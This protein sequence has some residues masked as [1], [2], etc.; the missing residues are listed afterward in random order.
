MREFWSLALICAILYLFLADA[1]NAPQIHDEDNFVP[2]TFEVADEEVTLDEEDKSVT[3]QSTQKYITA[4]QPTAP[5]ETKESAK[6]DNL[7]SQHDVPKDGSDQSS[8]KGHQ[9]GMDSD[10][11]FPTPFDVEQLDMRHVDTISYKFVS[12]S[13]K[14]TELYYKPNSDNKVTF[15]SYAS[16]LLKGSY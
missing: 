9:D 12:K 13:Q 14:I 5:I 7:G 16:L 8:S 6:D 1:Q 2:L 11:E 15:C 10:I 4:E 3:T